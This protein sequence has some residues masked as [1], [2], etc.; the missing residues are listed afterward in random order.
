MP[1]AAGVS[2][3]GN[4]RWNKSKIASPF[5]AKKRPAGEILEERLQRQVGQMES[6]RMEKNRK[7]QKRIRTQ[8]MA[9]LKEKEDVIIIIEF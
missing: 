3:I 2:Q 6:K 8:N 5:R 1:Q 7:N 9:G 4:W